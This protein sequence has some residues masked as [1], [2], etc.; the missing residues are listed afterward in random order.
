LTAGEPRHFGAT[1]SK[2]L[3]IRLIEP[4]PPSINILSYGFYPRLGLP[5]IGAALKAAGHDVRIYCPQ[6]A[7]IDT[8]DVAGADLVGISTTTSTAPAAYSLADGLRAAGLAVVIGGPHPTFVSD[9]ALP[10]AD[11]VARGEGGDALMLELVEAMAGDRELE[12]IDGLSFLRDGRPVHNEA[13]E[14]CADLDSL[15]VPDLSLIA[16]AERIRETPIMTSLGC[17]FDCTFCTV[18][19]M[20]GRS[21]RHRSPEN[22]V[23]EIEA[24]KPRSVFFYD[25]NFAADKRRLKAMLRMMIDRGLTPK[26]QAQVTKDID[27]VDYDA[28]FP[29]PAPASLEEGERLFELADEPMP[30]T[31]PASPDSLMR[32][33]FDKRPEVAGAQLEHDSVLKFAKSEKDLW[34]PSLSTVSSVGVI[35]GHVSYLPDHYAALGINVNLPLFNGHLFAARRH[36]AELKAEAADQHVRDLQNSIARDIRV[37]WLNANTA[38][39]R[40]SLTDQLLLEANQALDLAQARYNIGLS[41]IVELSQAQLNL[42]QAQIANVSAKY[43]YQIRRAVLDYQAGALR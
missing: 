41:S 12:S 11:F 15:P 26:W 7:P 23:A 42:T 34:L 8:A 27:V 38:E 10:H 31:L 1:R 21:Y 17:P 40:L 2:S 22:V 25:D 3:K 19:M 33:A 13:R 32:T 35:P 14:R 43:D 5:L 4:A 29:A 28:L 18:T 9:D 24:K 37:A 36:E 16:G 6:A 39:Q 20:F 30:A